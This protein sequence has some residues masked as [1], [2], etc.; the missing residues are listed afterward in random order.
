MLRRHHSTVC[1][2]THISYVTWLACCM[3]CLFSIENDA[4]STSRKLIWLCHVTV[5]L[6]VT[7]F[8][9]YCCFIIIFFVWNYFKFERIFFIKFDQSRYVWHIT[10]GH[11]VNTHDI[12]IYV[13]WLSSITLVTSRYV[14]FFTTY[15]CSLKLPNA[16]CF[17][18]SWVMSVKL[19][20]K[21]TKYLVF[22]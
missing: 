10:C 22:L 20:S 15:N 14:F 3:S 19:L 13:T 17:V 4:S 8:F 1:C 11:S 18:K 16:L 21:I 6:Y 5:T 12:I 7:N 2:I 9:T